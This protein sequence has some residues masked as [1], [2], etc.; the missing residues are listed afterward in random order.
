M[1]LHQLLA[2]DGFSC[3]CGKRHYA[4]LK[5]LILEDGALNRLPDIVKKY[6][7]TRVFLLCD[8]HT[9]NAAGNQAEALL[10]AAGIEVRVYCFTESHLF[11][12]EKTVGKTALAFDQTCDCIVSVGSGVLND[13]GKVIAALTGRPYIIVA[14]APSMDGYAS[15]TSSMEYNGLK[16]SIP[17]VCPDAVLGDTQ[18]L[19][20]APERMI[21]AGIG[22]MTAK[23]ISLFEWELA[24]LLLGEYYCPWIASLVQ[25]TLD[26]CMN[27]APAA[28]RRE[29][30]AVKTVMEG[31]ILAGISMN[32]AG[33]SR[34]ASG[35]EHYISHLWDMRGLAFGT[36]VDLHGIQCGIGTLIVLKAYQAVT[37]FVP[38][39]EKAMAAVNSF[40]PETWNSFLREY[41]GPGAEEMI[42]KEKTEQKYSHEKHAKRLDMILTHWDEIL[43]NIRQDLP[44]PE[45]LEQRLNEIGFPTSP[46]KIGLSQEEVK[47]AFL[48][49]KDIR[50]KYVGGR[51]FWDL[52]ILDELA[53]LV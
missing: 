47:G 36:P 5:D 46:E 39:R 35:M 27:A 14:T 8:K 18:V 28:L 40:C 31:M 51:L 29:P 26:Q 45:T 21:L 2:E 38:D 24:H 33:V 48:A 16:V 6:N 19:C 10:T 52:G 9:R 37:N 49:A 42:E 1:T 32:Y 43:R 44:R 50:D 53:N 11:L 34:P 15:A 7:G 22:D 3:A 30:E 12:D 13:T 17:S 4:K 25:Q 20:Q 41:V 23:Y